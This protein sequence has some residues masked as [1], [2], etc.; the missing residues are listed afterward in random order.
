MLASWP[1]AGVP[2]SHDT[3]SLSQSQA[4]NQD[5]L[6]HMVSAE[7]ESISQGNSLC[8]LRKIICA[9]SDLLLITSLANA[10]G[11]SRTILMLLRR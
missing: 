7:P 4:E 3:T 11:L 2:G 5:S 1:R 8:V 6:G 10:H 9:G